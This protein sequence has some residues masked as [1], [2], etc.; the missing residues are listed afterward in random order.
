MP[1][2]IKDPSLATQGELKIE[3]ASQHMPVL[4]K[5]RDRFQREQ[6]FRTL[7]IGMCMHLEMKTAV[8][9][10][11]LQ[12]AGATIAITGSNPLSTQDDVAASLASTG[13]NV[14]AWRG[15][16][17][18][19]HHDNLL[20][21][22][23]AKP[24]IL[25]DDGGELSVTVHRGKQELTK[26][27]I[28]ACEET[29]T[30]VHR[31]K[32]MERDGILGYP[33]MA[34]N[35]AFTKFLFDSQHGTGQSALEG[36]MRAT[37][38]LIAGKNFVVAGYGWVGRGIALRAKGL[39]ARVI[40]TEVDP[41]KA[42]EAAMEGHRVMPMTEASKI[43][44]IFVSATGCKGIINGDH[45]ALMHDG[46]ILANSGHFDVEIDVQGLRKL[47]VTTRIAR[48]N[49]EEFKLKNGNRL[50]L[51]AEGRL[52]NLAAADGHPA[53][54]MDMSFANQALAAEYLVKNKGKLTPTV[55][56]IPIEIDREVARL[57]LESHE[58]RL[59][60]LTKEQNDYLNSWS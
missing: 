29:T 15:V 16:T 31:Y 48:Q 26:R 34:V 57:W 41:I 9:G 30:G 19:E 2:K 38:L 32:A 50:Y 46:A 43:G 25:I 37:N 14:F 54:V 42:L 6:P 22:L 12:S 53:E 11:T 7:T 55:H 33:V 17:D 13:A 59:D 24:D 47:A 18:K 27:L 58:M 1:S 5:I 60:E 40:V 56:R 28:G 10:L 20:R 52:V 23:D 36:I 44:D 21:V 4:R 8:L 51:L 35:D 45:F 49:V 39:G 3:W